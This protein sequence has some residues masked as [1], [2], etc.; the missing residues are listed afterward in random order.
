MTQLS[1]DSDRIVKS[2]GHSDRSITSNP[3]NIRKVYARDLLD[4]RGSEIYT[5]FGAPSIS[6]RAIGA[7]AIE[8][9][10]VRQECR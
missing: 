7:T 10:D 4:R 2:C 1:N 3:L 6:F 9:A 8:F 5:G